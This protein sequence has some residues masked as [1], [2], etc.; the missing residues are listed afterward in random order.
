MHFIKTNKIKPTNDV[1]TNDADKILLLVP[2][3]FVQISAVYQH[4]PSFGEFLV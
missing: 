1:N 2:A 4:Y 3:A